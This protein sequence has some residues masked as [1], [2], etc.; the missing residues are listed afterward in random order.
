MS[1]RFFSTV[2]AA[3]ALCC[4][5]APSAPAFTG[6]GEGCPDQDFEQAFAQF[7][8][9]RLYTLVENGSFQNGLTGWQT[10]GGAAVVPEINPFRPVLGAGALLM[11]PGSSAV[12]PA[13]CVAKGYP[14]ARVFVQRLGLRAGGLRVEVLYPAR[15]GKSAFTK[16]AGT[17]RGATAFAPSRRFSLAQGRIGGGTSLIRFR[18]SV[19]G[20]AAY[21]LDDILVD[22]RCRS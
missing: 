8:D 13:V 15:Q 22:P 18:F 16:S 9:R 12:S 21:V 3:G 6:S 20:G 19:R 17:L 14:S 1:R 10:D 5:F 11:P 4:G 7:K 2:L